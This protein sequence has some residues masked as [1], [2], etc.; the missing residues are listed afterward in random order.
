MRRKKVTAREYLTVIGL[1][2]LLVWLLLL[3]WGILKKE[4]VA[5]RTAEE[6]KRQLEALTV[7]E[8]TLRQNIAELKTERGQ[9]AS[10]RETYGVARPGEEVI[11]VVPSEERET[12]PKPSFWDRLFGWFKF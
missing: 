1:S 9:E 4:E 6:T 8:A 5:R 10:L 11:I 7:R 2:L 3:F 12:V